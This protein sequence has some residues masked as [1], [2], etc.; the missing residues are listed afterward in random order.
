[1]CCVRSCRRFLLN[2]FHSFFY[3]VGY[4]LV[5]R[6]RQTDWDGF[7]AEF[8]LLRSFFP[9]NQ[10][11]LLCGLVDAVFGTK[12]KVCMLIKCFKFISVTRKNLAVDVQDRLFGLVLFSVQYPQYGSWGWLM[13]YQC[14]Q[15]QEERISA[16]LWCKGW[17]EVRHVWVVWEYWSSS[18]RFTW[19]GRS[20]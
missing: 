16:D 2:L 20:E 5:R 1:M 8:L 12:L 9:G 18:G 13:L 19:L 15:R 4:D 14:A 11:G 3:I 17:K 10:T 6:F 7:G